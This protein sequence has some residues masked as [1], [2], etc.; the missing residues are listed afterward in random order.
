M[1]DRSFDGLGHKFANNIYGSTKGRLRHALL[2]H[3]LHAHDFFAKPTA[4]VL[5]V[6]CGLGTMCSEFVSRG[7]T[8]QGIDLSEEV[9]RIAQTTPE[10]KHAHFAVQ[11]LADTTGQYDLILC[12]AM[13]EW[14]SEPLHAIDQLLAL[15]AP[16][17]KLS[18]SFFSKEA[19]LYTNMVY[20]NF[21]Y[22]ERGM[23]SKK[24]VKLNPQAPVSYQTVLGHLA[25]KPVN[26]LHTAGLRCIHDNMRHIT[27]QEEKYEALLAA[28]I[29]YGT[30]VPYKYLGRYFHIILERAAT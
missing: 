26:I 28:E 12:H 1:Q 21:D 11:S 30:Q 22:I 3:H 16:K 8:P 4:S 24:T 6:G 7:F 14:V 18:L 20:G 10:L 19:H 25:N 15:L 23:S 17:G 27:Q 5:D 29:E 2:L 13:L 9:I